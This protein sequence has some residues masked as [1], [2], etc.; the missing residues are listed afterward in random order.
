MLSC[1]IYLLQ[2]SHHAQAYLQD[3][4]MND[5]CQNVN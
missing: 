5:A 1:K 2:L 3:T 4:D